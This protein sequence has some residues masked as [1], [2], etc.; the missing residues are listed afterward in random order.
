MLGLKFIISIIAITVLFVDLYKRK[1]YLFQI[2]ALFVASTTLFVLRDGVINDI[3]F[4]SI[5]LVIQ[6]SVLL[7]YILVIRK[8]S[9]SKALGA[10]DVLFLSATVPLFSTV[11]FITFYISGLIFSYA[12]GTVIVR[13]AS[14]HMRTIPLAG[15]MGAWLIPFLFI[16]LDQVW[17][18][19]LLIW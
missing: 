15:L 18:I 1:I 19:E 9:L 13:M 12:I 8:L 5:W 7:I 11:Q 10:G 6:L 14:D 17:L 3:V 2:V 4:N 16:E